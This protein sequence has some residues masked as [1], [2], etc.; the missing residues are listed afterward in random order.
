MWY[1]M[2]TQQG[3]ISQQSLLNN[4]YFAFSILYAII[5]KNTNINDKGVD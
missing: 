3:R 2:K 5:K 1:K 4:R